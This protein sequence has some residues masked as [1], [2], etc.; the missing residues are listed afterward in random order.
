MKIKTIHDGWDCVPE[1][2]D[3]TYELST[4]S[5]YIYEIKNCVRNSDLESM[6][7]DMRE[8]MDNVK[9]HLDKIDTT[10]EFITVDIE[11]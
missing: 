7:N 10:K 9:Y 6:V 11:D 8:I 1:L 4:V 5:D 3:V 2:K